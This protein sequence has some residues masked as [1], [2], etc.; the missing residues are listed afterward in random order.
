MT[1]AEIKM[2]ELTASV[3]NGSATLREFESWLEHHK[4]LGHFQTF[5]SEL[6]AYNALRGRYHSARPAPVKKPGQGIA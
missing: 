4:L 3:I 1:E 6:E 2:A 5:M